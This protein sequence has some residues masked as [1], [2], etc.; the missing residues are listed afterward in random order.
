MMFGYEVEPL[1]DG[2]D[3]LPP[4]GAGASGSAPSGIGS[5]T[6]GLG[7]SGAGGGTSIVRRSCEDAADDAPCEDGS[8][9]T[10]GDH[11]RAGECIAGPRRDCSVGDGACSE[12]ACDESL[13]V[14]VPNPIAEGQPC[15]T[16]AICAGGRCSIVIG[17]CVEPTCDRVCLATGFPCS[18]NCA[19]SDE[20]RTSC[21][22]G[23]ACIVAC[24]ADRCELECGAAAFCSLDCS[25]AS[26]CDAEC[27][28]GSTCVIDC[29]G[30]EDCSRL[31]CAPGAQ[32][33]VE[34]EGATECSFEE[35]GAGQVSCENGLVACG[36]CPR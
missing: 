8:F 18:I 17:P 15:G 34:C 7:G 12:G 9:C 26:R 10:E 35:C 23:S 19:D 21:N 33:V 4:S 28:T 25:G 30:A 27:A 20:C 3:V 13:D 36:S 29:E 2:T 6:A 5:G 11:C 1:P 22:P 16:G 32:C 14:C 24:G 31:R